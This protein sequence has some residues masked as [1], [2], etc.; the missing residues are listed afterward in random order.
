MLAA[1]LIEATHSYQLSFFNWELESIH[2]FVA[3]IERYPRTQLR[4]QCHQGDCL[5]QVPHVV[6]SLLDHGSELHSKKPRLS[7]GAEHLWESECS[8]DVFPIEQFWRSPSRGYSDT[9]IPTKL[10]SIGCESA[11]ACSNQPADL[12]QGRSNRI[13]LRMRRRFCVGRMFQD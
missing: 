6:L 13:V 4:R 3:D 8:S 7:G 1:F 12:E 11:C 10:V 9:V 2:T 5:E